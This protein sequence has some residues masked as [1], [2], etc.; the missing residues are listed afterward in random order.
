M[1]PSQPI[2]DRSDSVILARSCPATVALA[3]LRSIYSSLRCQ[4]GRAPSSRPRLCCVFSPALPAT[5]RRSRSAPTSSTS[6]R[7]QIAIAPAAPPRT[8]SRRDFVPWRFSNAARPRAW[9]AS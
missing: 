1:T 9:L 7:G 4:S 5:D 3:M 6:G 2:D 8:T